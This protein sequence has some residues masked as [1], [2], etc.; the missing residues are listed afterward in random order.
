[1]NVREAHRT[2]HLVIRLDRGDELPAALARALDE[3]DAQSGFIT[4]VGALEAAELAHYDQQTRAFDKPRRLDAPCE[5]LSLT[6]NVAH[7][8]GAASVRLTAVLSRETDTGLQSFGGQLV[9]GRAFELELHVVVFDNLTL[10]RIADDRTGLPVLAGRSAIDAGHPRAPAAAPAQPAAPAAAPP[11]PAPPA[12][13]TPPPAPPPAPARPVTP[14]AAPPRT[15]TPDPPTPPAAPPA[16]PAMES[17]AMPQRPQ[18][19]REDVE[20]YPDAG[21]SVMHFAF[22]ECTVLSSD[23][24][25]IRLRQDKDGRVREVALAMLRIEA[26]S[27]GAEGARHFKLH[28]KN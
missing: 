13:H 18:K 15:F 11:A 7:L 17:N 24:D 6:G 23:G 4:G 5:V 21:N 10:T 26:T 8:D 20:N 22:G 1:M 14:P 28:R 9:W 25:R 19:P 12:A 27:T 3:A 16:A 2:R